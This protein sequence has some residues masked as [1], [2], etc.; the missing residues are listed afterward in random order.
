MTAAASSAGAHAIVSGMGRAFFGP[1]ASIVVLALCASAL[2]LADAIPARASVSIAVTWDGLLRASTAAA[3]VT[4]ADATSVWENGR[5]LTYTHVTIDRA[6]AGPVTTGGDA[7]VRTLGG[8]VGNLG[9][10][11]EGEAGFSPG[12]P[13]LVF[14]R[15][16]PEGAQS[17]TFDVTARGQGQ[18]PVVAADG[19]QPARVVR[20][21]PAGMIVPP[22]IFSPLVEP[23]L[24]AD[25]LHDCTVD[26][27]TRTIQS[28]WSRLHAQ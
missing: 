16:H 27:A 20:S 18:F 28:A 2:G 11:V 17:G 12:R 26:E 23:R 21:R 14:L 6:V 10:Q 9:Q 8:I 5:I 3:V 22:R 15:A 1:R 4:P 13:S 7:W 24:A 19:Q 25:I